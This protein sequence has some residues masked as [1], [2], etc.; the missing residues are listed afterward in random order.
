MSSD[1]YLG[2]TGEGVS[3]IHGT[4]TLNLKKLRELEGLTFCRDGVHALQRLEGLVNL[5]DEIVQL[6]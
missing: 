3:D 4:V 1:L 5:L 6:I 2:I